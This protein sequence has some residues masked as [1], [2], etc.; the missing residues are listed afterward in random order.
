[1]PTARRTAA[2]RP[3]PDAH[4][5]DVPQGPESNKQERVPT[6]HRSTQNKAIDGS[7]CKRK[8]TSIIC[9]EQLF[10]DV[11][12]QFLQETIESPPLMH[13][14]HSLFQMLCQSFE[15]EFPNC[16]PHGVVDQI[17]LSLHYDVL[18]ATVA[19]TITLVRGR[20]VL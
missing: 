18:A 1:M 16:L 13:T 12:Q 3:K 15:Q 7:K 4:V 10:A 2:T 8:R 19:S 11:Q 9:C 14:P 17:L 20:Q 5:P 6:R